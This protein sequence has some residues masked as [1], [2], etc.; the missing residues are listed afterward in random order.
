M[1]SITK[2]QV[3]EY[4]ENLTLLEAADLVKTLEENSALVH[5]HLLLLLL[6]ELLAVKV[7]KSKLNLLLC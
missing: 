1:S 3:V 7:L 4:L 2:E 5:L 6:L